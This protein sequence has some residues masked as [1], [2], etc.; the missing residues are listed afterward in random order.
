MSFNFDP[1]TTH[2]TCFSYDAAGNQINDAVH[3]Y[4]YDAEGNVIKV[5]NGSTASYTYDALNR[6][7]RVQTSASTYEYL[8][9]PAGR[10]L[11]SWLLNGSAEGFGNEGRIWWDGGLLA[12]RDWNGQTYFSHSDWLG[13]ERMRTNY[14][15][16]IATTSKSLAFGDG[17]SQSSSDPQGAT[18][19]NNEFAGQDS[20]FESGTTHA[21]FRQYAPTQGRWMSPDPYDG[22]YDRGNPQSFN[23][24]TYVL[25]NP[26]AYR[27]PSGLFCEYGHEDSTELLDEVDYNSSSGECASTGGV[28]VADGYGYAGGSIGSTE[29]PGGS[30]SVAPDK[31]CAAA[32]KAA[33]KN[34]GAV[35]RARSSSSTL[36]AA[37]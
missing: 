29:L 18:Q 10:R 11:S 36:S 5:D 33:N 34:Q 19:D 35:S 8:F 26:F 15:G 1:A 7:V 31:L 22:S 23:R 27:D 4:T 30:P 21:T 28:W 25:N 16:Q 17:F 3:G 13:T 2:N 37:A 6:R 32:L 12:T 24:Y 14:Q 20:D 9:D